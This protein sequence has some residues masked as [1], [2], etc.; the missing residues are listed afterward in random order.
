MTPK[1]KICGLTLLEDARYCAGA[2]ADYLGFIQ[3][4]ASPRYIRP[5]KAKEIID[6]VYGPEAVGVFVDAGA[7]AVNRT[8][9]AAGFALVQLHGDEPPEVCAQIER[10]VIKALSV[11]PDATPEGLRAEMARYA[12][13]VAYFLLDTYKAGLRGGT[14]E[15]FDWEQARALTADF[16]CFI[17]GGLGAHNIADAAARLQPFGLDVSSSVESA[18][19]I[20]D[21]DK[22]ADLFGAFNALRES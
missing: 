18:P 14:G 16:P 20:K 7:D 13:H 11:R 12:P 15:V 9:D 8:A 21:F 3:Y 2:G 17:A 5:E 6:W 4:E 22:L 10:P 19:G 1:L